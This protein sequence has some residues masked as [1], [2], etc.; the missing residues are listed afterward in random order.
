MGPESEDAFWKEATLS[1]F[2]L[3][4]KKYKKIQLNILY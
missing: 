1:T 4:E 2:V 3:N